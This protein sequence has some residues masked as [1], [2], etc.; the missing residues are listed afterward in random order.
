MRKGDNLPLCSPRENLPSSGDLFGRHMGDL[1]SAHQAKHPR[2]DVGGAPSLPSQPG[3]ALVCSVLQGTRLRCWRVDNLLTGYL[4][5]SIVFDDRWRHCVCSCGVVLA[6]WWGAECPSKRD[7]PWSFLP[8]PSQYVCGAEF[9]GMPFLL[10]AF[11]IPGFERNVGW[12][13]RSRTLLPSVVH[14]RPTV[15]VALAME[16]SG[17][18]GAP[19]GIIGNEMS[20]TSISWSAT[21][22]LPYS[23]DSASPPIN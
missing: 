17:T 16:V 10:P 13:D 18:G 20:G 5:G 6:E 19:Q 21:P 14:R 9:C 1:A 8:A 23:S 7:H 4:A 11:W 3:L 15:V 2:V 12:N 22:Y